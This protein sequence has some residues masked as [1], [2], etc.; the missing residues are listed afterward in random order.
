MGEWKPW[1]R[2][3]VSHMHHGDFYHGEKSM[4]LDKARTVRME[5]IAKGGKITVL[6]PEG[7]AARR[8]DHRLHVHEQEGPVRLLREG[9]GRLP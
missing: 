1:S 9:T 3:H 6:K 8:R 5:L 4:T 2:T 7:R